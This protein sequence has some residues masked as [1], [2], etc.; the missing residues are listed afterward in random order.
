MKTYVCSVCGYVY[1]EAKGIPEAGIAPGTP[2]E[3]L[4]ADWVCPLCGA[5]KNA[6]RLQGAPTQAAPP[7]SPPPEVERELSAMEMSI[8]CSNLARGC[9]KQYLDQ[10]AAAFTR[11]A[12]HFRTQAVPPPAADFAGLLALVNEDLSRAYPYA[13]AV[14]GAAGDR[15][16]LRTLEWSEKVSN[17]L[18]SLLERYEREGAAMLQNSGVYV[19]TICGFVS[20]GDGPPPLCPVCKVPSWKFEK[21]EGR[22]K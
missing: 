3:A 5:G 10:E 16:A 7:P 4:G 11:L 6:F 17:M 2:W 1:D 19:C 21:I 20:V 22:A 13:H 9:E 14:A 12:D 8:L 15:G 18:K